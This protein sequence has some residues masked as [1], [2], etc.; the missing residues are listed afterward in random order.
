MK[1]WP[2][3]TSSKPYNAYYER[4]A[5]LSLLPEV[6]NR[7]VLD[8]G[9]AA[10]WYTKWLLERGAEVTALDFSPRMLEMARKRVGDKA[11]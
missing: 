4:P 6:Q 8:A 7:A 5:T 3:I 1:S 10:D 2:S 11:N 9:C